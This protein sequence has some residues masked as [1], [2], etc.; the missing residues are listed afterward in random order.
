MTAQPLR[1]QPPL[2]AARRRTTAADAVYTIAVDASEHGIY[3][4]GAGYGG[5]HGT[6]RGRDH[7]EYDVYS[8]DGSVS[9]SSLDTALTDR[10]ARFRWDGVDGV[11]VFEFAHSRSRSYTYRPT[12]LVG[13]SI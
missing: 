10:P 6:R 12:L 4:A 7:L 11:G 1:L 2:A 5:W 3:M 9:P 13:R 8:L